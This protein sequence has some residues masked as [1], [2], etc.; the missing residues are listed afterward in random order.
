MLRTLIKDTQTLDTIAAPANGAAVSLT[1]ASTFSAQC[2]VTVNTAAAGTFTVV[3]ATDVITKTAHGLYTG[4]VVQVSNSG[5]ALPAGLSAVTNYYVIR[6]NANTFY[7]A[8]SLANAQA[9]TR[10]DITDA[11]TGTQTVTPTALATATVKLQKSDD[12]TNWADEGSSVS[13][14]ATGTYWLEKIDPTALY[15][16]VAYSLASGSFLSS[17]ICLT[18][19]DVP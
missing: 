3:A 10:I 9:G 15:M 5:G 11:G 18:Q 19:G 8:S 13:I 2:N 16:R 17:T 12:G 6:I 14:T 7:L 4:S 1:H